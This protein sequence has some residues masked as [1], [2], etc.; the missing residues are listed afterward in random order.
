[1]PFVVVNKLSLNFRSRRSL[2]VKRLQ[3]RLHGDGFEIVAPRRSSNR[4]IIT[5]IWDSRHWMARVHTRR[6]VRDIH[7]V[8]D[9]HNKLYYRGRYW[10]MSFSKGATFK[11]DL[12]DEDKM[13]CTLPE[14]KIAQHQLTQ[15]FQAQTHQ[16]VNAVMQSVCPILGKWPTKVVLKQ[17]KT[18]WGSCGINDTIQINWRLIFAP[19][20]IL[21]YVVVHELCHLLHRNHGVRF[22]KTVAR[23]FPDH[24]ISRKWLREEGDL[25]MRMDIEVPFCSQESFRSLSEPL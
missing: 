14:G 22:W 3:L 18:R 21:E 2:R 20:G 25:L 4:E 17:Q 9:I 13:I 12:I 24:P 7:F 11:I 16:I 15:W 23:F 6:A 1:M 10:W 5:F 8:R 19:E